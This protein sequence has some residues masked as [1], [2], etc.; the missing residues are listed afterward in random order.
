MNRT[1]A[2]L[3]WAKL[4]GAHRVQITQR[5][6]K[7]T[8]PCTQVLFLKPVE[9]KPGQP[10]TGEGPNGCNLRRER[11]ASYPFAD[12]EVFLQDLQRL[13]AQYGRLMDWRKVSITQGMVISVNVSTLPD[14]P[15]PMLSFASYGRSL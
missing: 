15:M 3:A 14:F 1:K 6:L 12:A 10:R 5:V 13:G 2:L 4:E 7:E 8:G 9:P 11:V